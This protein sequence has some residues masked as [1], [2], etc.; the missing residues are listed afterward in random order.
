MAN[1][2]NAG[3]VEQWSMVVIYDPVSGDILHTHE[4]MTLRGGTHPD[5][6]ALEK[7][8]RDHALR[9]GRDAGNASLLH[10]D[11]TGVKSGAQYKVDTKSPALV[12]IAQPKRKTGKGK[13]VK[14]KT[15]KRKTTT[16]KAPKR[17]A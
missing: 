10:V 9:A 1:A 17:K 12:E 5:K 8:A 6:K 4:S 14:G 13:T 15:V 2:E 11:P 16:G 3:E 7:D